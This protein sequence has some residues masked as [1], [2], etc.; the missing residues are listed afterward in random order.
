MRTFPAIFVTALLLASPLVLAAPPEKAADGGLS[1]ACARSGNKMPCTLSRLIRTSTVGPGETRAYSNGSYESEGTVTV[2][3]GGTLVVDN[4][5]ITFRATSGGFHVKAGGTLRITQSIL[6]ASDGGSP[7]EVKADPASTLTLTG[8][9]LERGNGLDLQTSDAEVHHDTFR[10]IA[11]AARLTNVVMTLHNSTFEN[12][13][14]SVNQTG[15][16]TT[17]ADNAFFGGE[18]CV[19]DW[20]A[21]PTIIRNV[22][23]GCHIGIFHHRSE[24]TFILNDMEDQAHEPG[25]GII[26]QDTRS[27][28][29]E[30]NLIRNY[31]TG[32]LVINARAYIRNNT[33]EDNVLDGV[34]VVQNSAPMDI[35]TNVIRNNGRD[36]IRLVDVAGV[37]VTGN[38][39]SGNGAKGIAVDGA[40][41]TIL[42]G[43]L[44]DS[45]AG[46]GVLAQDAASIVIEENIAYQNGLTGFRVEGSPTSVLRSNQAEGNGQNGFYTNS[47]D[48][49]FVQNIAEDNAHSGFVVE[50]AEGASFYQDEAFSNL[51]DGFGLVR[52]TGAFLNATESHGAGRHGYRLQNVTSVNLVDTLAQAAALDGYHVDTPIAGAVTLD[53]ARAFDNGRDGAHNAQGNATF[54]QNGWWQGNGRAGV[55][56]LDPGTWTNAQ[57]SYWGSVNGPTVPDGNPEGGD[58]IFGQVIYEPYREAPPGTPLLIEGDFIG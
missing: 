31:G 45:N 53:F 6:R 12:N 5:T 23:R 48:V 26:V 51:I 22:F 55:A 36:G 25:T 18:T 28:Y 50:D 16:M 37:D 2:E 54:A 30:D 44:L 52:A 21:D 29:I 49:N 47:D 57:F 20:L 19:R 9:T 35:T 7:F 43:N 10:L 27:P 56:N 11:V 38:T 24:S 41:R 40:A 34:R 39:V 1:N 58:A 13:T 15:G 42:D 17:L 46:H 32:I 3:S 4:A 8:T 14:V 33:I